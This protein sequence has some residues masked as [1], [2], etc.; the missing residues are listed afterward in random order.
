MRPLTQMHLR[1]WR[2]FVL[3]FWVRSSA[4]YATT[5]KSISVTSVA[6]SETITELFVVL[7]DDVMFLLLGGIRLFEVGAGGAVRSTDATE[8]RCARAGG[9]ADDAGAVSM[10]DRSFEITSTW[11]VNKITIID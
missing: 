5:A 4:A 9:P 11:K 2:A 6:S 8:G 3:S 7:G 1:M 10:I